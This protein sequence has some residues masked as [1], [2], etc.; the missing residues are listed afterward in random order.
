[1]KRWISLL[2]VCS[3]LILPACKKASA[4]W[5]EQYDLG[6]K[7]LSDGNY[8]EAILSFSEAIDIDP[9]LPD[10]YIGRADAY[11]GEAA[12]LAEGGITPGT[13]QAQQI[14]TCLQNAEADY[15][16]AANLISDGQKT[17]TEAG[18]LQ[19]KL[20]QT[21]ERRTQVAAAEE[22]AASV[23][24]F[25][26][27]YM[28]ETQAL[29]DDILLLLDYAI[30]L[31]ALEDS[32]AEQLEWILDDDDL[33]GHGEL[34]INTIASPGSYRNTQLFA[35]ADLA[36]LEA[37]THTGAA[38]NSSFTGVTLDDTFRIL[39][40]SGYFTIGYTASNYRLWNGTGWDSF[41]HLESSPAFDDDGNVIGDDG[42]AFW[43]GLDISPAEFYA[44]ESSAIT[45]L[46]YD[47]PDLSD[48][49]I[50]RE[51]RY[52]LLAVET[53]LANRGYNAEIVTADLDG[54]GQEETVYLLPNAAQHWFDNLTYSLL[55]EDECFLGYADSDVTALVASVDGTGVRLRTARLG[56]WDGSSPVVTDTGL[57]LG[58]TEY[59]YHN[60]GTAFTTG[61]SA[62][63]GRTLALEYIQLT[64][65]E[66]WE[67]Q[68]VVVPV[69]NFHWS[70]YSR[71]DYEQNGGGHVFSIAITEEYRGDHPNY[72]AFGMLT[73]TDPDTGAVSN[74]EV[75]LFFP[76]DVQFT[77]ANAEQYLL[78]NSTFRDVLATMTGWNGA[79]FWPY[80]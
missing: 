61:S 31:S 70:F 67:D 10:A 3:I 78:L 56:S 18:I 79:E 58:S 29:T 40:N 48:H 30:L 69:D 52:V 35:D 36:Y 68:F 33:D 77:E 76:T 25:D 16:K 8:Q 47:S 37:F 55:W 14:L 27:A 9:T 64:I 49:L 13:E 34:H 26:E 72:E 73:V 22:Q 71:A 4:A 62:S 1:M 45:Q 11:I 19:A 5:Q 80:I 66:S 59:I 63:G 54:D 74:P 75:I 43:N 57:R 23:A 20:D 41:A 24:Q 39:W 38:G 42:Y 12:K 46:A 60:E 32:G 6:A 17:D 53:W 65:P 21:A 2:L 51:P 50:E 15:Q 7:Y 44:V 28:A